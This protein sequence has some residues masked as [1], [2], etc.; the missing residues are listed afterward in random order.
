MRFICTLALVFVLTTSFAYGQERV[1][2]YHGDGKIH[3]TFD[4]G[5]HGVHTPRLLD[6]L[7]KYGVKATFFVLGKNAKAHPEIIKRMVREGHVV[8]SHS[9]SHPQLTKIEEEDLHYQIE[10]TERVLKEILG[11]DMRLMRPPYGATNEDIRKYLYGRGYKIIMWNVDT[12]D[13]K[14]KDVDK[15]VSHT[16]EKTP[17]NGGIILLHDIHKTSV[18]AVPPLLEALKE[19]GHTFTDLKHFTENRGNQRPVSRPE[20]APLPGDDEVRP[21]DGTGTVDATKLNFRRGPS[22][23]HPV[24]AALEKGTEVKVLGSHNGW[25]KVRISTPNG[26]KVAWTSGKYLK[27]K[28][29]PGVIGTLRRS[30]R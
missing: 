7:K 26:P 20:P 15:I 12:L 13:W 9:F 21:L 30:T 28:P 25:Y 1:W 24:L 27:F 14:F 16:L 2:G 3:M 23:D 10:E 17:K 11:K 22:T 5:P 8:A 19:R 18:D 4:D 29:T 6:I